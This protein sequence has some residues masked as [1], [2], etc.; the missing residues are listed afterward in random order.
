MDDKSLSLLNVFE[1]EVEGATHHMVC[2]LDPVLAGSRG[3]DSRSVIGE[4]TPDAQGEFDPRTFRINP[5]FIEAFVQYMNA[6]STGATEAIAQ[7]RDQPGGWLYL[8]D[9]RNPRRPEVETPPGDLVGC[10]AVDDTGQIVPNSF[11]YN[12]NHLWFDPVSGV[13]GLLYDRKFYDWLH[14]VRE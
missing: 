14:P 2:Y 6:E 5:E 3:I 11:Q 10:F 9:P 12:Q 8:I 13:S 1:V 4:F 7:A